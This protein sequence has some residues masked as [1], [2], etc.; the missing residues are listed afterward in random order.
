MLDYLKS[1]DKGA[2]KEKFT[3]ARLASNFKFTLASAILH[4]PARCLMRIYFPNFTLARL[5]TDFE[6]TLA[7][8]N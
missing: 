3:L 2:H 4:S 5:A 6:F 7:S 8:E 1:E